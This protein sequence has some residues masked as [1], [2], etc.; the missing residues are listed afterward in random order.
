MWENLTKSSIHL[1][2]HLSAHHEHLIDDD[3]HDDCQLFL[4]AVRHELFEFTLDWKTQ[5]WVQGV[6]IHNER[7]HTSGSSY[8]QSISKEKSQALSQVF[9]AVPETIILRGCHTIL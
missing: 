1:T 4:Q 5:Q 2:K 7:S 8:S 6:A 9:P 3:V